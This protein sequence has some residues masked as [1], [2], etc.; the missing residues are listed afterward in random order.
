[1]KKDRRGLPI[2]Y[3]T[4]RDKKTNKPLFTVNDAKMVK[5][6]LLH[7]RCGICGGK[8]GETIFFVGGPAAAFHPNGAYSD[9]PMHEECAVYALQVCPFLAIRK[10]QDDKATY[11]YEREDIVVDQEQIKGKPALFV[12]KEAHGFINMGNYEQVRCKPFDQVSLQYWLNGERIEEEDPR[13]EE[14]IIEALGAVEESR[15]DVKLAQ[16]YTAPQSGVRSLA[17][18]LAYKD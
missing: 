5:R 1:M 14:A 3:I 17:T 12:L 6:C 18:G 7:N 8:L 16:G 2:P 13:V 11:L 10:Y 9:P 15:A 4:M